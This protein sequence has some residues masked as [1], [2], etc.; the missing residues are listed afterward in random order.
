MNEHES[1]RRRN[2]IQAKMNKKKKISKSLLKLKLG[3]R[4]GT[5]FI[6]LYFFLF[7]SVF[8]CHADIEFYFECVCCVCVVIAA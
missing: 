7:V 5:E 4:K 6:S 1:S 8:V 2:T 3:C